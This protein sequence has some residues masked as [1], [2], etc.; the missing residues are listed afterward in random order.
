[1]EDILHTCD[2]LTSE[3]P[4]KDYQLT[5]EE[6][7]LFERRYENGFDLTTDSR[8]IDW[9]QLHYPEEANRLT[10]KATIGTDNVELPL[11]LSL[12]QHLCSTKNR[13][14]KP[15][16]LYCLHMCTQSADQLHCES[17]CEPSCQPWKNPEFCKLKL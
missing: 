10:F 16:L 1:M 12:L 2:N 13:A 6:E 14:P 4:E 7:T 17:A 5:V 8:Y 9:L 15:Q 11:L 3:S